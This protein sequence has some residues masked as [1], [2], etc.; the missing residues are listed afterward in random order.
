MLNQHSHKLQFPNFTLYINT[1]LHN[2]SLV[3]FAIIITNDLV[4]FLSLRVSI[5][6][7]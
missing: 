7:K 5:N 6:Y 4:K 1:T 2:Y 3:I